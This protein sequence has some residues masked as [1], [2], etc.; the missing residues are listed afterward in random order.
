MSMIVTRLLS[1]VII[2]SLLLSLSGCVQPD[3]GHEPEEYI[4]NYTECNSTTYY[5]GEHSVKTVHVV[6]NTS[7]LELV[8][9]GAV[10]SSTPETGLS[11]LVVVKRTETDTPL[12]Y[13]ISS[14]VRHGRRYL[15]IEFPRSA[16]F[17][18]YTETLSGN[19]LSR[20]TGDGLVRV[21]LPEGYATGSLLLGTPRPSPERVFEDSSGR[22]VI[23]WNG[24]NVS[25]F[26]V[27]YYKESAPWVLTSL[28]I[29]L[30]V[31]GILI[32]TYFKLKIGALQRKRDFVEK[33]GR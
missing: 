31:A 19:E 17:V 32:L 5:I 25:A 1:S 4:F 11:N 23:E 33:K 27:A 29:I 12:K 26:S 22:M 14:R 16:D 21:Y 7:R 10:L 13:N 30:G 8:L 2:L 24:S 6:H 28:F 20:K 3:S 18:A 9:E 15:V